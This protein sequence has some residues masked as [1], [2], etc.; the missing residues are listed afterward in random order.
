[1]TGTASFP[2]IRSDPY[3]EKMRL[4]QCHVGRPLIPVAEYVAA[5]D[6]GP[7]SAA[8]A[9]VMKVATTDGFAVEHGRNESII[10]YRGYRLGGVE[11]LKGL[12]FVSATLASDVVDEFLR[13]MKFRQRTGTFGAASQSWYELDVLLV[14][15]FEH[16]LSEIANAVDR[17][18]SRRELE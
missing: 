6:L 3:D 2:G 7:A 11:R 15:E 13:T 14:P 4:R 8:W 16:T 17:Q 5:A 12:W 1:M 9:L 10:C 18:L